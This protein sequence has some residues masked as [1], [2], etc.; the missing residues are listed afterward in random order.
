MK[1]MK[2]FLSFKNTSNVFLFVL[3][4]FLFVACSNKQKQYNILDFGAVDNSEQYSTEAI[5]QAINAAN[6]AGGGI[7]YVPKGTFLTG[8]ICLKSNVTLYVEEGATLLGSTDALQYN[9]TEG[10]RFKGFIW[11]IGESNI[12]IKGKGTINGRGDELAMDIIIRMAN[13]TI[14]APEYMVIELQKALESGHDFYANEGPRP[15][16]PFRP[17]L[18]YFKDCSDINVQDATFTNSTCWTVTMFDCKN[19][20]IDNISVFSTAFWNNDGI[21]IVDCQNVLI[22]NCNVDSADDG[23]CL[24][25]EN[26]DSF[27]DNITVENCN[28][29][30]SASAIKFGTASHGGFRNITISDIIVYNTFRSAVALESVDGGFFEN[31]HV[32][33]IHATNTGNAIFMIAGTRRGIS[34][35]NNVVVE[36]LYCEVPATKPDEGYNIGGPKVKATHNIVPSLITGSKESYIKD[37]VLKNI[38]IVFAGGAS[39]NIAYCD[40]KDLSKQMDEKYGHYPEFSMF[41]ELPAWGL[42]VRHVDGITLEN[43]KLRLQKEDYRHALVFDESKNISIDGL[44]VYNEKKNPILLQNAK[45]T[46]MENIYSDVE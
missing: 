37:V 21:D 33:N 24:K 29:R 17:M 1:T 10:S 31:V 34:T 2:S 11:A 27:C 35:F 7:V 41:G 6:E 22:R 4:S 3:M 28:V 8:S 16:E 12:A 14:E 42:L 19:I 5:Q 44:F 25:S 26:A 32:K 15:E 23:I 38:E 39:E 45:I 18:V 46:K 30:S 43:V 36:N 9:I 13:R 20:N 40:V